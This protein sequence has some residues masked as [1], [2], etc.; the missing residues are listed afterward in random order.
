VARG[1]FGT[2][3]QLPSG[4]FRALYYGP[5]G[6]RYGAPTMFTSRKAARGWLSLRQSEIIRKAWEPPEAAPG[7]E[8]EA[9]FG[10]YTE[11]WLATRDLKDRTRERYCSLLER[12]LLKRFGTLPMTSISASGTADSAR[13][14]PP[15]GH[16]PT[17]CC[18]PSCAPQSPTG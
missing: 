6:R 17:A 1:T 4:R 8:A 10:E 7:A 16:T 14:H 11:S 12:H 5:D 15:N 9:D 18:G 3:H 13:R 2:V